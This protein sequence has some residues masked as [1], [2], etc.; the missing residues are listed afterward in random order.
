M[1]D[2]E[3]LVR[4]VLA[5]TLDPHN[6]APLSTWLK[7]AG[8]EGDRVAAELELGYPFERR[9][10]EFGALVRRA[11]E[12]DHRVA[13][14]TV[15]LHSRIVAHKVQ[16][17]LA[18]LPRVRNIVPV[19]SGKGGVGKSTVS[20][21][22]ALALHQEGARVGVLDADIYGPSQPRMFGLA[23]KPEV[24]GER[25]IVPPANH[26]IPLISMGFLLEGE[27]QP[28]IWRGPMVSQALQQLLTETAW[29]ELDYLVVDLPPGTGDIQLTLLQKVPV[30]GA[31]VVTTPQDMALAD[32][33]KALR[34][35]EKLEVPVLGV[36]ENMSTHVC[37]ACG[38]EDA[39]FGS[40]GGERMASEYGVGWLGRLP[41][42]RAI[43]EQTDSGRPTVV[44][45]PDSDLAQ[46]YRDV[47]V[48]VAARL[49][50]Q[51]VNQAV[52]DLNLS[53]SA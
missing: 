50:L 24:T 1:S 45:E 10:A 34:M 37:S 33:R 29:P 2:I 46:R 44:A 41:L 15:D 21:N 6:D 39:V 4:E 16:K 38:H 35:F 52:P 26:G 12:S 32:A 42:D 27:D 31:V 36:V 51:P 17:D 53:V 47:A 25:K 13:S 11:L 49:A 20:A 48:R 22:L 40:G 5:A 30:S 43:C 19:A 14:A 18:P 9:R 23:G 28:A 8:G 3:D 7:H